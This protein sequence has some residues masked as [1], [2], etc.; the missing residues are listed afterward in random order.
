[1][2]SNNSP[3]RLISDVLR[4]VNDLTEEVE[5]FKDE[6]IALYTSKEDT[7]TITDA[8]GNPVVVPTYYA[9]QKEII[10]G[11]P[12]A[13]VAE[14]LANERAI[15]LTGAVQGTTEFDGSAD[16]T[17]VT[18]IPAG[19]LPTSAVNGLDTQLQSVNNKIDATNVTVTALQNQVS[20][21]IFGKTF[22]QTEPATEWVVNHG[23][24]KYPAVTVMDSAGNEIE[25]AVEHIDLNNLVISSVYPITGTASFN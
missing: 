25:C 21:G 6:Q 5:S 3:V 11:D 22:N 9:L 1:M 24:N 2:A 10:G 23:M 16:V 14:K 13:I 17:I 19:S 18:V 20:S 15:N 7:V 8:D 4:G 12:G